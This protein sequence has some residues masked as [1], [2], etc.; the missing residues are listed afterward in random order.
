MILGLYLRS[1]QFEVPEAFQRKLVFKHLDSFVHLLLLGIVCGSIR[2]P[3][4]LANNTLAAFSFVFLQAQG[5][6]PLPSLSSDHLWIPHGLPQ[7]IRWPRPLWNLVGWDSRLKRSQR[8]QTSRMSSPEI[9]NAGKP[10]LH[11]PFTSSWRDALGAATN[12]N[13]VWS[14]GRKIEVGLRKWRRL[15][16]RWQFAVTS[17]LEMLRFCILFC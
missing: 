11:L 8:K 16:Y 2:K 9:R 17:G 14:L 4:T 15:A 12:C 13:P 7:L 6:F 3:T 5:L 1:F 10:Y